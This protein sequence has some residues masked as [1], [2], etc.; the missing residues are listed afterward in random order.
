MPPLQNHQSGHG[1]NAV[2]CGQEREGLRDYRRSPDARRAAKQ[3]TL[4]ADLCWARGHEAG[5]NFFERP[6]F[7]A[8]IYI[9]ARPFGAPKEI[10]S[11]AIAWGPSSGAADNARRALGDANTV[12]CALPSA[13]PGQ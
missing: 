5:A 4:I 9:V 6:T 7:P 10:D 2:R 3:T 12:A 11:D 8:K 13:L 1:G